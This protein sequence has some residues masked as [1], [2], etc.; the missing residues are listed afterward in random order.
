MVK[1]MG[2]LP[3]IPDIHEFVEL[4]G[5]GIATVVNISEERGYFTD[6]PFPAGEEMQ[7]SFHVGDLDLLALE[8]SSLCSAGDVRRYLASYV[9]HFNSRLAM[10][11]STSVTRVYHSG[12]VQSVDG[13]SRVVRPDKVEPI[14]GKVIKVDT[15]IYCTGYI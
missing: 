3:E 1:P 8:V 5:R 2:D 10:R 15:T 6:F 11:L 7:T 12:A 13:A 14:D 9:E 4:F